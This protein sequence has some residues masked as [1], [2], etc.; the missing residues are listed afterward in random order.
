MREKLV[1][2]LSVLGFFLAVLFTPRSVIW[3]REVKGDTAG[4][5][6]DSALGFSWPIP[7]IQGSEEKQR[8]RTKASLRPDQ[9]NPPQQI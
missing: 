4:V 8:P 6:Q 3:G 9:T 5:N 7:L 2:H 1:Q